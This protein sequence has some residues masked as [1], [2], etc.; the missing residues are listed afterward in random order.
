M[1]HAMFKKTV[2]WLGI[3][4]LAHIAAMILFAM[5]MASSAES[6]AKESYADAYTAVMV[7][8]IVFYWAFAF[9]INRLETSFADYKRNLKNAIKAES[10]SPIRYYQRSL[11]KEKLIKVATIA[12]FH[13]PFAIFYQIFGLSLTET[14]GFEQFYILDAGFYG[15]AG[16]SIIGFLMA[17]VITAV[18]YFAIDVIG[19]AVECYVQKKEIASLHGQN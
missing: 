10:F 11:L 15:V 4:I 9:M 12:V 17:S 3:V 13:I 5:V 8:D 7:F 6:L 14:T 2:Q 19:F 18:I 1:N 16:S